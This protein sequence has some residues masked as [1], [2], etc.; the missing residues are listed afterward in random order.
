MG[1]WVWG[2]AKCMI[3]QDKSDNSDQ[4]KHMIKQDNS[5]NSW[6]FWALERPFG[7]E[8]MPLREEF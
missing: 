7:A 1:L 3:E 8:N 5:D 2:Q 6:S 4:A